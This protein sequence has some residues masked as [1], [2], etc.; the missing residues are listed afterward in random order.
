MRAPQRAA[1]RVVAQWRRARAGA[2]LHRSRLGGDPA[3]G[4]RA[5]GGELGAAVGVREQADG[6]AV[7]QVA[8]AP[9][10]EL[11]DDRPQLP[12]RIGEQQLVATGRVGAALDDAVRDEHR[13]SR[14]QH[15]ARD[16]EVIQQL[17]ETA[18][19]QEQIADD[20]QRP[21][22]PQ[23]FEERASAQDWRS[24]SRGSGMTVTVARS[25]Q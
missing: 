9:L 23:D 10:H 13:E 1:D 20:Q 3:G 19:A 5:G 8:L 11:V 25:V 14:A 16:V 18:D 6:A 4:A 2:R 7:D 22:L 24:Y 12:A 15:G 17:P 21:A